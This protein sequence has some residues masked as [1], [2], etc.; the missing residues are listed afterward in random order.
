MFLLSLPV[1][2]FLL[3]VVALVALRA[4]Y[5]YRNRAWLAVKLFRRTG[6]LWPLNFAP[7]S[8]GT[9][10]GP[11]TEIDSTKR[12]SNI[13]AINFLGGISVNP[14][15]FQG[16]FAAL[17]SQDITAD[18]TAIVVP[19]GPVGAAVGSGVIIHGGTAFTSLTLP[20]PVAGAASVGNGG[21]DGTLLLIFNDTAAKAHVV[22][23]PSNGVQGSLHIITMSSAGSTFSALLLIAW[24]GSWW[25][26]ANYNCAFT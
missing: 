14:A 24:N 12:L 18:S 19:P 11:N 21:Q 17:V 1:W 22:T 13:E 6:W 16:A 25:P 26:I 8:G 4:P 15:L 10:T 5:V 23:T 2:A 20:L 3:A 9:A 7:V